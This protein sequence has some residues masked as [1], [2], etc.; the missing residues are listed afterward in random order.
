MEPALTIVSQDCNLEF[1]LNPQLES[2]VAGGIL[3]VQNW[4]NLAFTLDLAQS[5]LC[6]DHIALQSS[7]N[8]EMIRFQVIALKDGN[9]VAWQRQVQK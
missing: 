4:S 2:E 6:N 3:V 5:V 7:N 9:K 1:V 8:I